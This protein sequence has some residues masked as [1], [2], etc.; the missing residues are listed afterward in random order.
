MRVYEFIEVD[1]ETPVQ[2][3]AVHPLRWDPE[4]GE[5]TAL[6]RQVSYEQQALF[7][8]A[9]EM[10]AALARAEQ[11]FRNLLQ[12]GGIVRMGTSCEIAE[13]EL[14]NMRAVLAKIRVESEADT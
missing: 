13:N 2:F 10:H 14:E 11:T 6:F 3:C 5:P 12:G 4:W 9:P 8:A 1:E 7:D